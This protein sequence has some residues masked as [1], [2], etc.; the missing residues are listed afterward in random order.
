L[1]AEEQSWEVKPYIEPGNST[2]VLEI[3]NYNTTERKAL[4]SECSDHTGINAC[5]KLKSED[6]TEYR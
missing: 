3:T 4:Y 2:E 1:V 6:F 5:S